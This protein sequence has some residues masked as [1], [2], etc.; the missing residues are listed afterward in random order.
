MNVPTAVRCAIA[1]GIAC[2]FSA[3]SSATEL[4]PGRIGNPPGSQLFQRIVYNPPLDDY[5]V[6]Y[7]DGRALVAHLST[8]GDFAN[9]VTLSPSLGVSHV[10]AAFNPDDQTFLVVYRRG[11]PPDIFGRYIN[12]DGTPIGD[13]FFIGTGNGPS[14][15]YSAASGRYVVTW[16]QFVSGGVVRYRVIDGDSTS[17][18]PQITAVGIAASGI[19]DALAYGSVA[20][21]FLVT[22]VREGGGGT[23]SNV[24]G[25]FISGNGM[26]V[27]PEFVINNGSETQTVPRVSY[28]SSTNRWF[29]MYEN[30]AGCG[31]GCAHVSGALVSNTGSI[32]A[33]F[34]VAATSAWDTPGTVTYN[35]VTDTFIAGWRSAFSNANVPAR[36]AEFSPVD[37]RQ[38]GPFFLLS[39]EDAGVESS[40]ARPDP[41]NPQAT[42]LWRIANGGDGIHAG[43]KNLQPPLPDT[44]PP[45]DVTDL[46]AQALLGGNPLPATAVG[47]TSPGP[48]ATDMRKTT[49][50]NLASYWR[51]PIRSTMVPEFITWDLG[52][53]K[54]ISNVRLRSR[55]SGNLFPVDYQIQVSLNNVSF[56]PVFSKVGAVPPPGTWVDHQLPDPN[57]RFVRL[58]ITK[59]RRTGPYYAAEVAEVQ[60]QEA[61]SGETL[62]L[63]WT[64]PGDDGDKG[65]A[66]SIDLR[67]STN[68]ITPGNFGS[69]TPLAPPTPLLAGSRQSVTRGGFPSEDIVYIALR[70]SDEVPNT[71]GLSNVLQFTTPGVPPAP[72]LG[73]A[74]SN[75]TGNSV[76][77]VW[78]P[79]GDDGNNGNA[80][81][82]D[83]R[84]WTSPIT[85]AN[86]KFLPSTVVPATNPKP[87]FESFTLGGLQNQRTYY[88]AIKALDEAGLASARNVGP[89]VT[90]TTLDVIEPAQVTDLAASIGA[91]GLVRLNAPAIRSSGESSPATSRNQATDRNAATYWSTPGRSTEQIEFLTLD[92]GGLNN[93]GRVR[94]LSRSPGAL[95]PHTLHIQVS[96]NNVNFATVLS[97]TGLPPTAGHW[98][99]F[100]FGPAP[101]RYVRILI[102]K[103]RLSAGGQYYAQIA[104]AE[105]YEVT[106]SNE[107][108]L[109]FTAP[110]DDASAGT[111]AFFDVRSSTA[112]I[113]DLGEFNAATPLNGEPVPGPA[114]SPMSFS[115]NAPEEGVT[116]FF[117]MR[118]HDD[119]GNQSAL[120]NLDSVTTNIVPPAPVSDL[121]A[122]NPTS[123]SISLSFTSMGDDGV[124][125]TAT[126]FD[127]RRSTSPI[128][129]ANFGAATP[130][131]GEPLPAV[132]GT[133]QGMIVSGLDPTTTYYFAMIVLDETGTPSLLSNVVSATTDA[134]D[135]TAPAAVADLAGSLPFNIDLVPAQA[136]RASSVD[137]PTTSFGKATD[138]IAASY[139][140]SA[141]KPAPAIEF[142]TVDTGAVRDIGEVRLLARP[143]G[144]LFPKDL[145]IQVSDN[146]VTFTTVA[147]ANDLPGTPGLLHT[148][149]F[150]AASGRYVR[151]RITETRKTGGNLYM[152]QIGEVQV[153]EASFFAG[154]VSIQFTAP[155]DDG[156]N[157]TASSYDLRY[158]N[159]PITDG[160]F[161]SAT[162]VVGEPL[163]QAAGSHETIEVNLTPGVYFFAIRTRDE[164]PNT[165]DL[166][167]VIGVFVP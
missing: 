19:A 83:I 104:E 44:T 27:G 158:S 74:V 40:A 63:S 94:L 153:F 35:P 88:F 18:T 22:Y 135:T 6:F 29:V 103:T 95:F 161:A 4:A 145:E 82:Y 140:A 122:F 147:S 151:I 33:R 138:G 99:T 67:W 31:G 162:P 11:S 5:L 47:S 131:T 118:A 68:P 129:P 32:V 66:A 120:S 36:A 91:G 72:V 133:L 45:E 90:A 152:A 105:A 150:P 17:A 26:S 166:S 54:N 167:N 2:S 48:S 37:G 149:S 1:A 77:L 3:L 97:R 8:D 126:S 65:V 25:R 137:H 42:F 75:P 64:A 80:T 110:G 61:T 24:L 164:V 96:N 9:Q 143:A 16:S 144:F 76:D 43:I 134:P 7:S 132:A 160:N 28:A 141:G 58:R 62:V 102:T 124:I 142:I 125:G 128:T 121:M 130:V 79:S 157:G 69:A 85:D 53:P 127:V 117:R 15:A 34:D 51:S 30:W 55:S 57:A 156:P 13:P 81:A 165:S 113:D 92:T 14:V 70:T 119:A 78:Q 49:D 46:S 84:R 52:A 89:P 98:H 39:D 87:P 41:V 59:T 159:A 123:N 93:L 115:F 60:I 148:L 73:F 50:G 21:K 56:T 116:L 136:I 114:G 106:S 23:K 86:F 107:V 10:T 71:S 108:T 100:D 139:W 109:G 112:S 20:Q 154:P 163:P 38:K 12:P 101:G 155:G 111:A 146:N